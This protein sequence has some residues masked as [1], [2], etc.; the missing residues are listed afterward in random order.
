MDWLKTTFNGWCTARRF[1]EIG[2]CRLC[3]GCDGQD[4]VAHYATCQGVHAVLSRCSLPVP[5]SVFELIGGSA[6]AQ[7]EFLLACVVCSV[8][9]S[10]HN[11]ARHTQKSMEA[12]DLEA[13]IKARLK[14][15]GQ[16]C[17]HIAR[18]LRAWQSR[19]R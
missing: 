1:Q 18:L 7:D 13:S 11:H 10:S 17:D 3:R 16:N 9:R 4:D 2:L 14:S 8:L 12:D 19:Y 5:S 6:R 15:L